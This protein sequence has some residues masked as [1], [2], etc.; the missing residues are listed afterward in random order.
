MSKV[1]ILVESLIRFWES[2]LQYDKFLMEPSTTVMV[3]ATVRELK[4]KVTK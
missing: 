1:I 4:K 3:E 2:K